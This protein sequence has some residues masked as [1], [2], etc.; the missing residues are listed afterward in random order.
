MCSCGFR[1]PT[2]VR[3]PRRLVP[4][5]FFR[6]GHGQKKNTNHYKINTFIIT[7]RI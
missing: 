6:V 1:G 2:K 4:L 5:S 7:L 3:R